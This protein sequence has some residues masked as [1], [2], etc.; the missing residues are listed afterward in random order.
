MNIRFRQNGFV[1]ILIV[2]SMLA[3]GGTILLVGLANNATNGS[4]ESAVIK[5]SYDA[6]TSARDALLGF[7]AGLQ[8]GGSRPGQLPKPDTLEN[9]AYN[10][11]SDN[12]C[13]SGLDPTGSAVLNGAA[14][15]SANLRCIGK[16]PWRT[17]NLQLRDTSEPDLLGNVPWYAAS[18]NLADLNFCMQILNPLTAA[19]NIAAYINCPVI[20][21]PAWPWL[22]VCDA[23]G[24]ILSDRVAFV[25]ILPGQALQTQSRTQTR[26]AASSDPRN[27]LDDIAVPAGWSSI[28]VAS[29][30]Q[31]FDNAGLKGEFISGEQNA[32][33]ND[34][35]VY[36]TVDELMAEVEKRVVTEVRESVIRHKN[37]YGTYPWLAPL[38][39]PSILD[40]A[41]V[42]NMNSPVAHSVKNNLEVKDT[43]IGFIPFHTTNTAARFMT[44]LSWAVVSSSDLAVPADNL[45]TGNP[46]NLTT[47]QSSFTCYGGVF[48][49]RIRL[50]GTASA[51]PRTFTTAQYNSLKIS[52]ISTPTAAC[53]YSNNQTIS[54]EPFVQST[55]TVNYSVQ[56]RF[57]GVGSWSTLP[58][59]YAGKQT[60]TVT[61]GSISTAQNPTAS[62]LPASTN[63]LSRRSVE[64][65]ATP[66]AIDVTDRWVPTTN[67][68]TTNIAP[69]DLFTATSS[70]KTGQMYSLGNSQSQ[71]A[72]IRSAP[73]LPDWYFSERWYEFMLAVISTDSTPNASGQSIN[74]SAACLSAGTRN[75]ID[76][77]F[78]SAGKP[79]IGQNRYSLSPTISNFL[80]GINA[81]SN[82]STFSAINTP[83]TGTYVDTIAII[84][85]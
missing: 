58:G 72:Q 81:V 45:V 41:A 55:T 83:I 24:K 21:G 30:C 48:Q 17:L 12:N 40:V 34:R 25:L 10:G 14:A 85:R 19:G 33:F 65:A 68:A 59:S 42:D 82:T 66:N 11:L 50:A 29:R 78:F 69:F 8:S 61:L 60:R 79:L 47:A 51:I 38:A 56:R 62:L 84:P 54:C 75:N 18:E 5:S 74:C 28:P 36:V 3:I 9:G 71:I 20:N 37:V 44:E 16:L 80:E 35:I 46:L 70:I 77:I 49:C 73:I 67:I 2:L 4:K 31:T 27:F 26:P 43:R 63:A 32:A 53:S 52:S 57:G 22:K 23:T 7:S 15:N 76:M 39:D 64:S 6:L 1:L 13:L